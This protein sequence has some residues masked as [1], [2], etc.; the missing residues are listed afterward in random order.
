MKISL[1]FAFVALISL[2][3]HRDDN[4]LVGERSV[5]V[6]AA[7]ELAVEEMRRT[8]V[9]ASIKIAQSIVETNWGTSILAR[10]AQNYFG[11]KCKSWWTGTTFYKVDDDRDAT[12]K[13]IPS[14][15]RAYETMQESFTDHSDFLLNSPFYTS[16]F[17]LDP[18]DYKAWAHGLKKCGYATDK[19]YALKLIDIIETYKLNQYDKIALGKE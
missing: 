19:S 9:P 15:F 13:L 6:S 14:C 5:F 7:S 11:I 16:L 2:G 17:N 8:N 1:L 12:G 4:E 18:M 3:L 10:E